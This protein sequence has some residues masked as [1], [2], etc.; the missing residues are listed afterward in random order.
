MSEDL[1]KTLEREKRA[2]LF[3]TIPLLI[4]SVLVLTFLLS[5]WET[6]LLFTDEALCLI[7]LSVLL[8]L[9]ISWTLVIAFFLWIRH[10]EK[11][12]NALTPPVSSSS[13]GGSP[14]S[15]ARAP[16]GGPRG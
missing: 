14:E 11:R 3:V 10:W 4:A 6:E 16:G 8:I 15:P 7:R 2:L 5:F 12:L 1:R 13:Q 9:L